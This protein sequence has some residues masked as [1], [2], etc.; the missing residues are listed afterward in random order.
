[1][2]EGVMS[3]IAVAAVLVL[4]LVIIKICVE[5]VVEAFP[6]T[7][8][9]CHDCGRCSLEAEPDYDHT[10]YTQSHYDVGKGSC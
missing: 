6:R 9:V 8:C 10:N 5:A 2:F 4:L 3:L 1:M 7:S